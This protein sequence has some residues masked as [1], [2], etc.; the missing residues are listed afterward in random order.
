MIVLWMIVSY[1]PLSYDHVLL[2]IQY[3]ELH[4]LSE[5]Y[6]DMQELLVN[7]FLL[8][9]GNVTLGTPCISRFNAFITRA[10]F[11]V[12]FSF[13]LF[14][15]ELFI[16]QNRID[17]VPRANARPTRTLADKLWFQ[18]L[19]SNISIE[20]SSGKVLGYLEYFGSRQKKQFYG[21]LV[22]N[23]ALSEPTRLVQFQLGIHI[24]GGTLWRDNCQLI[25]LSLIVLARQAQKNRN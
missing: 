6:H 20:L 13:C 5:Y 18:C 1:P 7:L 24:S 3:I 16:W 17:P 11:I 15:I 12:I 21:L 10:S 19:Q 9:K 8:S 4:F 22:S 23:T 25:G 2:S 14:L